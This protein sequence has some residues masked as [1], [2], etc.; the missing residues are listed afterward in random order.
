[1]A[2]SCAQSNYTIFFAKKQS[3][4]G[5]SQKIF[6]VVFYKKT[7]RRLLPSLQMKMLFRI[8]P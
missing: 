6:A 4:D 7:K 1:M 3:F 8:V 2:L 5:I